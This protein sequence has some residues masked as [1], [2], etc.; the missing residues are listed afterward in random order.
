[1]SKYYAISVGDS[2]VY[3]IASELDADRL[4]DDLVK[5]LEK[6]YPLGNVD[7]IA[8]LNVREIDASE[9]ANYK[10]YDANDE[11]RM[12][13]VLGRELQV[14]AADRKLNNNA[15]FDNISD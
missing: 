6:E 10:K 15:P 5:K 9:A 13:E 2:T 11:R 12:L 3:T 7:A 1:M 14:A 4:R 8:V